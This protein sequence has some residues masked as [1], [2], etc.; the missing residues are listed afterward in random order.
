MCEVRDLTFGCGNTAEGIALS[1]WRLQESVCRP[2]FAI[3]NSM[4]ALENALWLI[5]TRYISEAALNIPLVQTRGSA[6]V[7]YSF[8]ESAWLLLC[9]LCFLEPLLR[10]LWQRS[11][12]IIFGGILPL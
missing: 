3:P 4:N 11:K 1:A 7:E 6:K 5:G 10:R 8:R 12:A 2:L 9:C